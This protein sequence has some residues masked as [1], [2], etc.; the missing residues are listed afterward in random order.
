MQVTAVA[1]LCRGDGIWF[2]VH[3]T[4]G[5]AK[6]ARNMVAPCFGDTPCQAKTIHET[7]EGGK[8]GWFS[9]ISW[10]VLVEPK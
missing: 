7:H 6:R 9:V 3:S 5:V 8:V 1:N 2:L 10:I 4:L